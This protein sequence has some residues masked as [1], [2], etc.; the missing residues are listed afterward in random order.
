METLSCPIEIRESKTGP[1]LHGV[2]LQE[3][4]AAQGGRAEVF[5]PLSVVW[6]AD[7]PGIALLDEH[8]GSELSRAVPTRDKDGSL[9]IETPATPAILKAYETRRYFSVEFHSLREVQT[10]GGVREIQLAL[11][12]AAAMVS[13]PEYK[14]AFAEVRARA[15]RRVW[16]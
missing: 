7:P 16:L 3:G 1:M 9:R 12:E 5:A 15:H 2:V 14:Q 11:L 13:D 8:R 6:S 4:R 10:A